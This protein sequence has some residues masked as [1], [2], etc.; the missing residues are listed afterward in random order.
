[1]DTIAQEPSSAKSRSDAIVDERQRKVETM[2]QQIS[3]ESENRRARRARSD[4]A[5]LCK[6]KIG[7]KSGV[8]GREKWK[9]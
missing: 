4:H 1:M 5:V 8:S 9:R 3:S 6:N 2:D 7:T